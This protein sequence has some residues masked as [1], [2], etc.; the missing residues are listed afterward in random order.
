[1][2]CRAQEG[3]LIIDALA[4]G[5]MPG[6]PCEAAGGAATSETAEETNVEVR[7]NL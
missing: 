1:M 2:P 3:M 7:N 4:A 5:Q 6:Q